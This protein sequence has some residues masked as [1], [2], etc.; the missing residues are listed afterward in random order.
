MLLKISYLSIF[1]LWVC[2]G[3]RSF[4][5]FK[6]ISLNNTLLSFLHKKG[7]NYK[8]PSHLIC[9]LFIFFWNFSSKYLVVSNK[10][11][12]F[13]HVFFIVLDLRLTKVWVAAATLFYLL[14]HKVVRPFCVTSLEET[15]QTRRNGS[16]WLPF[17]YSHL[18]GTDQWVLTSPQVPVPMTKMITREYARPM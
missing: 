6:M 11:F 10:V 7:Y 14:W 1:L 13:A 3:T 15:V 8:A 12:T 5:S 17:L 9:S 4:T 2:K 18:W 16:R